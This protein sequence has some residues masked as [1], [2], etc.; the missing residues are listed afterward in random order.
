MEDVAAEHVA[1]REQV[2][3]EPVDREEIDDR[4]GTGEGLAGQVADEGPR[5]ES[6]ERQ[7]E[8]DAA[9]FA[10]QPAT[11]RGVFQGRYNGRMP[12]RVPAAL[13]LI[14]VAACGAPPS[15]LGPAPVFELPDLAGGRYSLAAAKGKVVVLDFWATWC[16]PCIEEIPEYADFYRRNQGKGVEVIGVVLES[17][18]P[19]E[20]V[21][22]VREYRIPY[23][24]LLGDERVQEAY[25]ANQGFPTTFVIDR[26]GT[27]QKRFLG[28]SPGKFESLQKAVDGALAEATK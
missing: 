19:Q 3:R 1:G 28:S 25:G 8:E 16:G 14:L 4:V 20:I 17:G 27:I 23:R 5:G 22:F 2:S 13:C 9:G 10:E 18:E 26:S 6:S 21:D 7:E 24:Q 12:A 11:A 15:R